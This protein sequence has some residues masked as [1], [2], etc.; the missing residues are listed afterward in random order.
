MTFTPVQP[1]RELPRRDDVA[2]ARLAAVG[3]ARAPVVLARDRALA[4]TGPLAA[5]LPSVQRGSV[6]VVGGL[7]GTGA[8]SAV[9][10]I[11]AAATAAGEWAAMVDDGGTLG[12]LAAA[13][14]GVDLARFAVVRDVPRDRWATVVAA[15]LD[16]VSVVVAELPRSVRVG[17][18]RRLAARARERAAVLVA[19]APDARTWP[20]EA[21]V[22]IH[23]RGGQWHGLGGGERGGDGV[24]VVRVPMLEIESRGRQPARLE[25]AG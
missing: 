9:L 19:F 4:L 10:G 16:G 6:V 23:A 14:A 20:A 17:D 2:R 21:A 7:M 11:A 22:R 13:E 5:A 1:V 24:L 25:L 18:A 15:L 3:A 8:T 12:G